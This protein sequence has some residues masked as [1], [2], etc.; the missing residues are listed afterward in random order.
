MNMNMGMGMGK[1]NKRMSVNTPVRTFY[2]ADSFLAIGLFN[3]NLSL[4]LGLY[5]SNTGNF[6]NSNAQTTTIDYDKASVL[7]HIAKFISDG[8]DK[9]ELRAML[10]CN[11]GATLTL[12]CKREQENQMAAYLILNKNNQT[13]SFKF[14]THT[15]QVKKDG[16]V[17]T[18]VIQSGLI[19]F[20]KTLNGYLSGIG[21]DLHLSKLPDEFQEEN[22]Q[23]SYSTGNSNS[24][25]YQN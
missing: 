5:D 24:N 19:T 3:S 2:A 1:K 11:N 22:P 17:I 9:N 12:E 8:L 25:G 18:E 16:Q 7:H 14:P 15:F 20:A 13:H 23:E 10:P 21:T 6:D 4:R